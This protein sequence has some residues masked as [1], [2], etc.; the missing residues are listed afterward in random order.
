MIEERRVVGDTSVFCKNCTAWHQ[1]TTTRGKCRRHAPVLSNK[2]DNGR[3]PATRSED[4]CLDF[5]AK[6]IRTGTP[7]S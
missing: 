1:K 7:E 5:M 6:E 3:W 4:W 2:D